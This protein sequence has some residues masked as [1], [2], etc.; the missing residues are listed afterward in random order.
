MSNFNHIFCYWWIRIKKGY[1]Y[2]A[3]VITRL[4]PA[5]LAD[6]FP[7][8]DIMNKVIGEFL[9]AHQPYPNL[10]AKVVFQVRIIS[11]IEKK[12]FIVFSLEFFFRSIY[13]DRK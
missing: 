10:I 13:L 3:R 1:P 8:Q 4:L 5:F 6:F 7:A 2:E 11:A 9:S 12:K